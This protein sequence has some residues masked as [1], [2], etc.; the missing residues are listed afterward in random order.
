MSQSTYITGHRGSATQLHPQVIIENSMDAF[1]HAI[2]NGADAI[3]CDIQVSNDFH[4]IICH[5]RKLTD[6][7]CYIPEPGEKKKS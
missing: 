7:A 6:Y 3:E 4:P 5:G 1:V 2:N